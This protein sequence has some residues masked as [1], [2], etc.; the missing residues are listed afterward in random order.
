MS[1]GQLG[2]GRPVAGPPREARITPAAW[3]YIGVVVLAAT[4]LVART[5]VLAATHAKNPWADLVVLQVLF[6]IC[7]SARAPLTSRQT[8]WSPS[9]AATLAAAVLLGPA[10]AAFVG[11][12]SLVSVRRQPLLGER[13]FNGAVHAL[14]GLA[15][16]SAYLAINHHVGL[17]DYQHFSRIMLAFAVAAVVHVA[18]NHGMIWMINRLN[19]PGGPPRAEA[20]ESSLTLLLASDLGY[21]SLGLVIASLWINLGWFSAV[22]VLVPLFVA[23]WAMAQFTEEQRAYTATMNALCQA[24]ET[25]DY[26]TRG[27]G[28]RVSRGAVMIARKIGMSSARTEAIKFAGMLH[29]VGKLGVPTQVLQKTGPLTEDEFAAIQLHPMRGLEIVR[30][31]GFLFEALNGIMHHHERIDGRGYPMGLAGH[32][33]PEF[34]RVIAV[35]DAFDSMTTTR[36]YREAKSIDLAIAELRQGAGSQF[37]PVVVEAFIA[38]I[39]QQ[40]WELPVP[41]GPPADLA[42]VTV[43]DHDDPTAPLQVVIP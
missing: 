43:Q 40:G 31:I 22:I 23:R 26:Y 17:P 34:A 18:A 35:A 3:V 21:A 9:S 13:L 2:I 8:I 1:S 33:I 19:R 41:A 42:M 14:S 25:K 24:V 6:L 4:V 39:G 16:G 7:D 36:S 29:D 5:P 32:E 37:D 30:E 28:D 11:A 15:A 10:A 38:A 20:S 12:V 27:H